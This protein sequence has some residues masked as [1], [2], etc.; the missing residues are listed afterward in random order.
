MEE[1][2]SRRRFRWL[3]GLR[4]LELT[5]SAGHVNI[6]AYI[7]TL[8]FNL[9]VMQVQPTRYADLIKRDKAEIIRYET[10]LKQH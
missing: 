10:A 5:F 8:K 7:A 1:K 2:S 3:I 6:Q 4:E 9:R